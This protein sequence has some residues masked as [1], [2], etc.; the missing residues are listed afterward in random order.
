MEPDA[1]TIWL[2]R[3]LLKEKAFIKN[4]FERFERHLEDQGLLT[5]DGKG[6]DANIVEASRQHNNDKEKEAIKSG[7]FE[8][9]N[10]RK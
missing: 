3:E 2:F 1:K 5:L 7:F 10:Y 6:M 9:S 8:V 4:K